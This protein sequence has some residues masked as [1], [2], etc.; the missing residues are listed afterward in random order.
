MKTFRHAAIA[1][2]AILSAVACNKEINETKPS[3][4]QGAEEGGIIINAVAGSL[5]TPDTKAVGVYGYQVVWESN[6]R[7][8]VTDGET[9][10]TFNLVEGV[11]EILGKFAQ[12]GTATL[13]GEVTGY[14]PASI[15]NSDGTVL[16]PT[17]QKW[18]E[19]LTGIP[20]TASATITGESGTEFCF[21]SLGGMLQ[22]VLTTT[23]GSLPMKSITVS[24]DNLATPIVLDCAGLTLSAAAKAAGLA[25]PAGKYTNVQLRFESSNGS[26]K[27][28]TSTSLDIKKGVVSKITL[29][30]SGFVSMYPDYLSFT[31]RGSSVPVSIKYDFGKPESFTFEYCLDLAADKWTSFTADPSKAGVQPI[32]TITDGQTVFLRGKN[33][34]ASINKENAQ[35]IFDFGASSNR[36]SAAGNIM[37][38]LDP[39]VKS[40]VVGD[41]AFKHLFRDAVQLVSA[42]KLPAMTLGKGCYSRMFSGCANLTEAPELPA[43][44]LAEICYEFMFRDTG[45]VTT[46]PMYASTLAYECCQYMYESCSSLVSAR[47]LSATNLAANCYESMFENCTSLI[48]APM[49]PSRTLADNCYAGM[50]LRCSSLR[51]APALPATEMVDNC[52][53]GMFEDCPSLVVAPE[54]P[55]MTLAGSCY[56][57]M[58]YGCTSLVN[59]PELPA[60]KLESM[61]YYSMFKKCSSLVNA[62][63]LPAS[64]LADKCYMEMYAG[65][66][67]L[68]TVSVNFTKWDIDYKTTL[69]WL[70]NVSGSGTFYCPSGLSETFGI[71]YIPE[72]WTVVSDKTPSNK[73]DL[74]WSNE[75]EG[76]YVCDVTVN[77]SAKKLVI[78]TSNLGADSMYDKGQSYSKAQLDALTMPEGWSLPT[79]ADMEALAALNFYDD[80]NE[81]ASCAVTSNRRYYI[82]YTHHVADNKNEARLWMKDDQPYDFY[83][84]RSDNVHGRTDLDTSS[85]YIRLVK[86]L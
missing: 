9:Q 61:C 24:A 82:P 13:S 6:D 77:G 39:E 4:C 17:A 65:C 5:G 42:P 30:L 27:T 49:L 60:T 59:A 71:S 28:M 8:A 22:L 29:A 64:T 52:Y 78:A 56:N 21:E 76:M 72:G 1:F 25:I 41:Y 81:G 51:I 18:S 36:V 23:E 83:W 31:A 32:V 12:E 54:L 45:L 86:H 34:K 20:M 37:S 55:A 10:A 40:S 68:K 75:I 47:A 44:Y 7:I 2:I 85:N 43:A 66:T 73:G 15:L 33:A 57:F 84:F 26:V 3:L 70:G 63:H 48:E 38:L 11:G 67:S 69:N 19:S 62:P 50:F 16:W 80:F 74:Y 53:I 35:W 58:F 46:A 79:Y 14:Y